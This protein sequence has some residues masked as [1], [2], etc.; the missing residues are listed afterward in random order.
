[1]EDN[2]RNGMKI[3]YPGTF[4]PVTFGHID[5]IRRALK[6]FDHIDI[7]VVE[8]SSKELHFSVEERV[9][10]IKMS[11]LETG[12]DRVNVTSFDSLL[13]DYMNKINCRTFIRGLRAN[14]DFEYEFQMQLVNRRLAPEITGLYL[15][16]SEE[17]MYLSSTIVREIARYDGD[18]STVVTVCVKEA[19]EKRFATSVESKSNEWKH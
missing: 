4:D 7:A 15:M 19:L 3:I 9:N 17:N 1:M 2:E 8:R 11:M 10:L 16:P 13:V 14:S 18:L 12:M 6:I 5:I